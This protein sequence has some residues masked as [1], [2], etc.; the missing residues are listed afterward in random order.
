MSNS[1]SRDAAAL[2]YKAMGAYASPGSDVEYR[3]LLARYRADSAFSEVVNGIAAGME[4]AILDVSERGLV[5]APSGK[6]SRFS[7]KIG[8]LRLN[9]GEREKVAMVLV[10]MA[11]GTVFYPTTDHLEDE[12]RTPFPSSLTDIR[13]KVVGIANQLRVAAEGDSYPAEELRPGW[14]LLLDLQEVMPDASRA[15]MSSVHGIVKV[16]LMRM[17]TYGLVRKEGREE[18]GDKTVFTPTHQLRIQLRELTLPNLYRVTAES[19]A[20]A[21]QG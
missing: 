19:A 14:S 20:E 13:E 6:K 8:D 9:M 21:N 7:I 3:H 17:L 10:H 2:L 12:G 11:I 5:I 1:E 4:L 18:I 15:S 16:C